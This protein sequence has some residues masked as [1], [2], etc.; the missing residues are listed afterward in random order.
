MVESF[1][2]LYSLDEEVRF[3]CFTDRLDNFA[4]SHPNVDIELNQVKAMVWPEATL[5]RYHYILEHITKPQKDVSH[6]A[7][8][9]ADMRF[10]NP[11]A[12]IREIKNS[13][14]IT[15]VMHPSYAKGHNGP[16]ASKT[17]R[18]NLLVRLLNR[19]FGEWEMRRSSKA[20]VP[21]W[22]RKQYVCGGFWFGEGRDLERMCRQLANHVDQDSEKGLVA[23]WHD[24]SHLNWAFANMPQTSLLGPEFCSDLSSEVDRLS[25]SEVI[26]EAVSKVERTR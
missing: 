23:R 13:K 9:D 22:R 24:E 19:G 20:Y 16:F 26:L 12:L 18:K 3:V 6:V 14:G 11:N 5:K 15:F 4:S 2:K 17:W 21:I 7:H 10:H 25:Q 1:C 8:I